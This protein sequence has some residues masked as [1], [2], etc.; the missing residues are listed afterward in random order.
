[1]RWFTKTIKWSDGEW[2]VPEFIQIINSI[3]EEIPKEYRHTVKFVFEHNDY[4]E[5]G[6]S[7]RIFIKADMVNNISGW[8]TW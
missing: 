4:G 1:M 5:D 7:A 2:T 3:V 8:D 6:S